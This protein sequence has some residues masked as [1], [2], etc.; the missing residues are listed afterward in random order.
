[1]TDAALWLGLIGFAWLAVF[2][3]LLAAGAPLGTLAWGGADRVLPKGR[4]LASL[5]SA[6]IALLGLWSMARALEL[7]GGPEAGPVH[8]AL[9]VLFLLSMVANLMSSSRIERLHGVP[10]TVILC[11][12]S[13]LAFFR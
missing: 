12:A 3:L 10:L 4:R 11:V 8:A 1:M 6:G 5:A 13:G 7:I 2:Q 9:C